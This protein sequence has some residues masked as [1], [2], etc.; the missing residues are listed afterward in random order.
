MMSR[1]N[2]KTG[3][4]LSRYNVSLIL[5]C[6]DT[7]CTRHNYIHDI[8]TTEFRNNSTIYVRISA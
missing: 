5:L 2:C 6:K 7:G 3:Q 8:A 1:Y 4:N